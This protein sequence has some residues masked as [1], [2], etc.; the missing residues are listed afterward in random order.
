MIDLQWI[1]T[2]AL[3]ANE[4]NQAFRSQTKLLAFESTVY[5]KKNRK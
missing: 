2:V 4:Q 3:A 1:F 5:S